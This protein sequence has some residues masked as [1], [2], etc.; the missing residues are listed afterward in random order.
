MYEKINFR[1]DLALER[2]DLYK[3]ANRLDNEINGIETEEEENSEKIRTVRVK[4]V[5]DNGAQAI[6][7]PVGDYITID[8]QKLKIATEEDIRQCCKCTFKG[9]TY[10]N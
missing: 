6:G 2:R 3:K 10:S 9:I 5:N 4:V 1:T 7:K 8:I